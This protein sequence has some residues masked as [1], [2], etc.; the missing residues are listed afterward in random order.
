[1]F[2]HSVARDRRGASAAEWIIIVLLMVFVGVGL[3]TVFGR[4]LVRR[5]TAAS[6]S[7]DTGNPQSKTQ[8]PIPGN[9]DQVG[10][11]GNAPVAPGNLPTISAPPANAPTTNPGS[12]FNARTPDRT[13]ANSGLTLANPT[14]WD[15]ATIL[16]GMTQI[17]QNLST[18]FDNVRCACASAL[19]SR[20]MAGPEAVDRLL[21]DL[22]RRAG[23]GTAPNYSA[24]PPPMVGNIPLDQYQAR[25]GALRDRL[26]NQSLDHGDLGEIQEL[27][28][29]AYSIV[30]TSGGTF[31]YSAAG[32]QNY[33]A[34]M[35]LGNGVDPGGTR[36]GAPGAANNTV[37][38]PN[39][40]QLATNI[41]NLQTG[42]SMTLG[43]DEFGPAGPD[44]NPDH[45]IVVGRDP[46]GRVYLY[47]PWPHSAPGA[48]AV[49]PQL[50][51]YDNNQA[52]FDYYMNNTMPTGGFIQY[53]PVRH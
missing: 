21:A 38:N 27:L 10:A 6:N 18:N 29:Q 44:G 26:A 34:I 42:E 49:P 25:L 24:G 28:Y 46:S 12:S 4:S 3:I 23:N 43:V 36:I 11:P 47:D 35:E 17:D 51:Y 5:L 19:A 7:L 20:I 14:G 53:S 9:A 50:V 41:N 1:M 52:V 37:T 39:S 15:P 33:Q 8:I 31:F 30:P 22:M 13:P 48:A 40:A 2:S 16:P 45:F 32:A